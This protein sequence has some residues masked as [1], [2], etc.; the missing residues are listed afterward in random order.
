MYLIH[1]FGRYLTNKHTHLLGIFI[2]LQAS[3][4]EMENSGG[5]RGVIAV[6]RSKHN[7]A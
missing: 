4:A 6:P 2:L 1:W 5:S 3:G 7:P